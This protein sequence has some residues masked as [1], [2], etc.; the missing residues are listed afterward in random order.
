[1]TDTISVG[2]EPWGVAF[3]PNGEAVYVTNAEDNT[4]LVT[5]TTSNT[6]TKTISGFDQPTAFGVFIKP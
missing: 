4:L 6:E 3:T 1:M 5:D 2:K